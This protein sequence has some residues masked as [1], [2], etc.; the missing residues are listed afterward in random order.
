MDRYF[1]SLLLFPAIG[2]II[3]GC[4]GFKSQPVSPNEALPVSALSGKVEANADL[5]R[6][7]HYLM[8]SGIIYVDTKC[9]D[10]PIIEIVP[11]REGNVHL[12]ILKFLE[13]APCYDCFRITGFYFEEP[14]QLSLDIRIDHP[15]DD[16]FYSVFDVRGIMMFDGSHEFPSTG[17]TASNPFIGDGSLIYADGY[18]ALYNGS[19]ISAPVGDLQKYFPGKLSTPAIPNSDINGYRYF[20]TA[21]MANKRNAFYAGSF[22]GQSFVFKLPSNYFVIG[23]AVDASWAPPIET[24]VD[25][26]LTD[27]GTDANCPEPWKIEVQDLGP[28][29][30][31]EGGIT[32]L[33]IDVYDW[34]GISTHHDPYI[35]CPEIF[36]G[37]SAATWVNDGYGYSRYEISVTNTNLASQGDYLCLIRV[38]ANE[39]DPVNMP[40]LDLTAYQLFDLQVSGTGSES[41]NLFWAKRA[42]SAFDDENSYGVTTLSDSSTV[43]TGMFYKSA[44]FGPGEPNETILVN[45]EG[46]YDTFIARYNS[47]GNLAWAKHTGGIT[48]DGGMGITS[49]SDDSTVVTGWFYNSVTF[50]PGESNQTILTSAGEDDIFIARYNPD[51]TLAWAKR[52]GG[53]SSIE[54]GTG[55]TKLSDNSIVATGQFG[56][57]ATFGPGE[58]NQTVLTTKGNYDI[59]IARYNPDGTLAW[60]KQAGGVCSEDRGYAITA[61]SDDSTV[62]TGLF[63]GIVTFGEGE[64][65]EIS[66]PSAGGIDIFVA[67]YN[68]D[69]TLAWAKRAGGPSIY[70]EC[71]HG[72][73]ALSDDSTVVTGQFYQSATFGT[74]EANQT[75]LI[76]AGWD[77]I[78]IARYNPDGTLAWAKHA[79]GG[80]SELGSGVTALSD[81]STVVTGCFAGSATF[82]LGEPNQTILACDGGWDIFIARYN[83]DGTLEWVKRAG[84]EYGVDQGNSITALSDDSSVVTGIFTEYATFGQDE[85]NEINLFANGGQDIFIARFFE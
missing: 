58:P 15:F 59:F 9:A 34:Q 29:L 36:N 27:F 22:S 63:E 24:P 48:D 16:L 49:L 43:I 70:I 44:T 28:G 31:E 19:T 5:T 56:E 81:D 35:E 42:G 13:G 39:N 67:R 62:V 46:G 80:F 79:G 38:E 11:A 72:I 14:D 6:N 82:G 25:N 65:N 73:T 26:P 40:W 18:T 23:Y 61:L 10:N 12:N 68:P 47:D 7:S 41:G 75:V 85:P 8:S 30:T 64:P 50:G 52:A 45:F 4:A 2:I 69:G 32:K 20:R 17:M 60:A 51:G 77:D 54:Y 21:D 3:C 37:A 71:G 57:S 1:R 84:G 55:I 74:G 76:S 53:E 66:L 33:Q 83:P 78:F